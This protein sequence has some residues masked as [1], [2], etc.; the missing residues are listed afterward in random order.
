M[1][2]YAL[3][4]TVYPF[5]YLGEDDFLALQMI[6]FVERLPAEW[7]P[8]W[9][10]MKKSSKRDQQ[11]ESKINYINYNTHSLLMFF[12][13]NEECKLEQKFADMVKEPRLAPL[14]TIIQGLMRFLP[15]S[16][17]TLDEALESL[18]ATAGE[19]WYE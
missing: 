17:I 5:W 8:K 2:I 4:F 13:D 10:K 9:E 18:E 12:K 15:S 6:G 3:V 7:Q 1:Q 11:V 19:Q 14:V 16:R